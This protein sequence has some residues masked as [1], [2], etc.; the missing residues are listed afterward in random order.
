MWTI[1]LAL[2]T[3]C[4]VPNKFVRAK[5]S[6]GSVNNAGVARWMSEQTE[7][8]SLTTTSNP[9]DED[10]ISDKTGLFAGILPFA[11]S[12]TDSGRVFFFLMGEQHL[13]GSALTLSQASMKPS[14]FPF[15][16]C[17]TL[18]SAVDAEDPRCAKV[19]YKG[20]LHPCSAVDDVGRDCDSVGRAA[21]FGKFPEMEEWPTDH[22][23]QVHEFLVD[24]IWMIANYG[25]GGDVS[26]EEYAKAV[27]EAHEIKGGYKLDSFDVKD[28]DIP[29]WDDYPARSRW[30]VRHSL[31]TSISTTD[32][33]DADAT[34]GNI[35]SITDGDSLTSST[36]LP[37][38]YLPDVDPTAVAMSK[39]NNEIIL[40]FSEAALAQRV[41]DDGK[42]CGGLMAGMPTC[43]QVAL[44]GKAVPTSDSNTLS[45]FSSSHPLADWL[46]KGGSHMSGGYYTIQLRKVVILDYFGG[47]TKIPIEDYLAYQ[48]PVT[49]DGDQ[50]GKKTS[51]HVHKNSSNG[52]GMHH[53]HGHGDGNGGGHGDGTDSGSGGGEYDHHSWGDYGK[54]GD[55]YDWGDHGKGGGKYDWGDH[56][57]GK[58]DWGDHGKGRHGCR[59][60]CSGSTGGWQVFFVF[61]TFAGSFLGGF[62]SEQ[63]SRRR[64]RGYDITGTEDVSSLKLKIENGE[65]C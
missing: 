56:G 27:P 10:D 31:F 35:R 23:F 9:L 55:G 57:K 2:L 43:A 51:D 29:S 12:P 38:F 36:G 53:G 4:S 6:F 47:P 46:S 62:V 1:A 7:W 14:V 22:D 24:S 61:A 15:G 25:G 49:E 63:L 11:A 26:G 17:G 44:Y 16:G 28:K 45:Y 8:G 64:R 34:F 33:E 13:H 32:V 18:E 40:T 39:S 37:I 50:S 41:T 20:S 65:K 19:T 3:A 5:P 60:C 59:D 30:V 54:V 21:L 58:Y 42:T 48:F 52:N